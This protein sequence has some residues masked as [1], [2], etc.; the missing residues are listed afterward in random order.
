MNSTFQDLK[1]L[2]NK[3][4]SWANSQDDIRIAVVVGSRARTDHPADK[5]GDLDLMIYANNIGQYFGNKDWLKKIGNVLISFIHQTIAGQ[6]EFL[7]LFE[8][9]CNVDF[10]FQLLNSFEKLLKLEELPD[11][12]KRGY[13]IILDKE[14]IGV[15]LKSVQFSPIK[16]QP[17]TEEIFLQV[18]NSFWY[19]SLYIAK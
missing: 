12:F 10:V 4:I 11:I 14:G 2:K 18:V 13:K 8:G 6:P 7:A 9:G 19:A 1:Q 3:F 5:W 15:H 17:P 16:V